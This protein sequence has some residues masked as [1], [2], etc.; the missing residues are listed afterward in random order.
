LH[1]LKEEVVELKKSTPHAMNEA[2][3]QAEF[4]DPSFVNDAKLQIRAKRAEYGLKS[5]TTWRVGK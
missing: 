1:E 2:F 3:Q 5:M 4:T